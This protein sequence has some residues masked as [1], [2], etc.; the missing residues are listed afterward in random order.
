MAIQ[1][2]CPE[3]KIFDGDLTEEA[4]LFKALAD[5]AR[6]TILATLART[7]HEVCVCDFTSG[8]DLNQSSVSHHLK[9]LKDAGLVT[10]ARRGTWGYYSL[11]PDA[12]RRLKSALAS[13]FPS[14]VHA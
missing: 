13:V 10:A 11:A 4:E 3:T 2:D 1:R 6:V 7:E 8:L 9:L 14:K 12:R 5:P